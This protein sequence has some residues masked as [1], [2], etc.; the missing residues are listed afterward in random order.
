MALAVTACGAPVAANPVPTPTPVTG[1]TVRAAFDNSGMKNAHFR[2][3][4]TLIVKGT[5]FPVTGDGVFQLVPKAAL[6]TNFRIQTYSSVGVVKFQE[7]TIGGRLYSRA[8][9]GRWTSKPETGSPFTITSYIGEEIIGG[10]GVW[11]VQSTAA[12][13]TTDSWIRESD[14]YIVQLTVKSKTGTMIL[15]FDSYNKSKVITK[16]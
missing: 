14:G 11:H 2:L 12:G 7:I 9:T 8:G 5:Y 1:D 3:H 16:P 4:G 10:A 15:E 13:T 6:A